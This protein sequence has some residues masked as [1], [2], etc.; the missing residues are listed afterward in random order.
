MCLQTFGSIAPKDPQ[1]TPV[2]ILIIFIIKTVAF[3]DVS[4]TKSFLENVS[5]ATSRHTSAV[6]VLGRQ[7]QHIPHHRQP[8][9]LVGRSWRIHPRDFRRLLNCEYE[10]T[11]RSKMPD[12][13]IFPSAISLHI[14][15][16]YLNHVSTF[17]V[18]YNKCF[19]R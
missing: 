9:L 19:Y 13:V 3:S 5:P 11:S 4:A 10:L 17:T 1:W 14:K 2:P 15:I 12:I 18:Q 8:A 7:L 6:P 16:R